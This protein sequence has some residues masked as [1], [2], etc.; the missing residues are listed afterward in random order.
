[1][2]TN[3]FDVVGE[4]GEDETRDDENHDEEAEF[5]DALAEGEDDGLEAARVAGELE[6][7]G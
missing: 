3:H 7:P 4:A 1:M 5:G 6:D 2:T